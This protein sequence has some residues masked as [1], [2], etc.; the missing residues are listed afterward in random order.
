L[1]IFRTKSK[2]IITCVISVPYWGWYD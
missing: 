2:H 1:K